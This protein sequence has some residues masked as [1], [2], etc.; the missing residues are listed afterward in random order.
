VFI[1]STIKASI[2]L[3][4]EDT[5]ALDMTEPMEGA[6]SNLQIEDKTAM[7]SIESTDMA[8]TMNSILH[9]ADSL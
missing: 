3:Q 6:C 4:I 8:E 7:N 2:N 5:P 9:T 1:N